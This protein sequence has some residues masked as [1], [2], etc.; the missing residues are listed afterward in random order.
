MENHFIYP[1]KDIDDL[2]ISSILQ[3]RDL[4]QVAQINKY[5]NNYI[6]NLPLIKEIKEYNSKRHYTRYSELL[7]DNL[8]ISVCGYG[9]IKSSIS[10]IG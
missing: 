5:Y 9:L 3:I 7:L 8:F 2:I 10:L 4:F 6:S 1:I